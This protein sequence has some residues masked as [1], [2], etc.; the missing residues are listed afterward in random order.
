MNRLA[1]LSGLTGLG[2]IIVGAALYRQ[3][4]QQPSG[5]GRLS[6]KQVSEAPVISERRRGGIKTQL[7][8]SREMP[9]EER[10]A[11][12]QRMVREGVQDGRM[13][14]LALDVTKHCPERDGLCEAKAVYDYVKKRVRY[15]GDIAPIAWEDGSV[16]GVDLYQS[17]ARTLEMAGGD[18]DDQSILIATLLSLNGITSRLRV[19]KEAKDDDWSHIYPLAGLDK[20]NPT[21]WV[22]LDTT[23]PGRNRFG[24]EVPHA[25]FLDFPA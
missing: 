10:L 1:W 4:K 23:L 9:I 20:F 15:T 5:L 22:A 14:K 7:R 24:V 3:R 11:T 18:C 2:L 16:E 12:I 6:L 19:M 13:R 21:R 17:S 8:A 25:D